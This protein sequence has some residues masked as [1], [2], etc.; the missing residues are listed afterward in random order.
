[1]SVLNFL[2]TSLNH[3]CQCCG[4]ELASEFG[5]ESSAPTSEFEYCNSNI[6]RLCCALSACTYCRFSTV[7]PISSVHQSA[8]TS[9]LALSFACILLLLLVLCMCS[10]CSFSLRYVRLFRWCVKRSKAIWLPPVSQ[11][12]LAGRRWKL[13]AAA[14]AAVP[15]SPV[16]FTDSTIQLVIRLDSHL[17]QL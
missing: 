2:L 5:G 3:Y 17:R 10:L 9:D 16:S 4:G 15:P 13:A 14:A 7:F 6:A 1:M 11:Q 8:W 12:Q